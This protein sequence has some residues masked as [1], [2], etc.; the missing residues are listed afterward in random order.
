[1]LLICLYVHFN[2]LETGRMPSGLPMDTLSM[3]TYQSFSC[4]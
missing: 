1:L 3:T 2:H 4:E